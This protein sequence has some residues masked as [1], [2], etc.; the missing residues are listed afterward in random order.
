MKRSFFVALAIL[1]L[2]ASNLGAQNL[3]QWKIL[4]S[5]SGGMEMLIADS[6]HNLFAQANNIMR[7]TDYGKTWTDMAPGHPS[8][9][10]V[11]GMSIGRDSTIYVT[12][13]FGCFRSTDQGV[14]WDSMKTVPYTHKVIESKPGTLIS[15]M[16]YGSLGGVERSTNKGQ[17]WTRILPGAAYDVAADGKGVV[18]A[19]GQFTW[20]QI[21]D[22]DGATWQLFDMGS[23]IFLDLEVSH[24]GDIICGTRDSG[25][26]IVRKTNGTWTPIHPPTAPKE[27]VL[28]IAIDSQNNIYATFM[29]KLYQ[30]TD[31][32]MTWRM[33]NTDQISQITY[34]A[35]GRMYGFRGNDI[36]RLE[37]PSAVKA[38]QRSA[39]ILIRD[40]TLT[41][42]NETVDNELCLMDIAGRTRMR[43]YLEHLGPNDIPLPSDICTGIYLCRTADR[44]ER[45][46]VP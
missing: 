43:V 31:S 8:F 23:Q 3:A 18:V 27:H 9:S 19:G 16:Q 46:F 1:T 36:F 12:A 26:Y 15:V 35:D 42:Q 44:I 45:L 32:G 14:T 10:Y 22:D 34:A 33:I 2:S 29:Y 13:N 17:T 30:S 41:V 38:K 4:S 11:S 24:T 37:W 28:S 40:R 21:S 7:S 20:L 6:A 5:V 25:I 39:G